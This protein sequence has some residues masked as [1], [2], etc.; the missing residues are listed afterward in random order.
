MNESTFI[1]S[2]KGEHRAKTHA[3]TVEARGKFII[4]LILQNQLKFMLFVACCR[5]EQNH[6]SVYKPKDF[7][8]NGPN[9][10]LWVQASH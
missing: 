7:E 5:L 3:H 4:V 1:T 9:G 6:L 10:R 2:F 8:S